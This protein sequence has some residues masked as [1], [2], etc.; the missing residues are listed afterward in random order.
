M[1]KLAGI[2]VRVLVSEEDG[3]KGELGPA[4]SPSMLSGGSAGFTI[5]R[6]FAAR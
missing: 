4:P 6:P 5:R 2:V 3:K 1:K